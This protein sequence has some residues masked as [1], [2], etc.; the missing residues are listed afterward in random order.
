VN[1]ALQAG[2][3]EPN[4]RR[5]HTRA[6]D[7]GRIVLTLVL[8]QRPSADHDRE[9]AE[10]YDDGKQ[11]GPFGYGKDGAADGGCGRWRGGGDDGVEA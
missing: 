3:R 4:G 6:E 2:D 10:W 7:I 5:A 8:G 1:S 9:Q 11:P